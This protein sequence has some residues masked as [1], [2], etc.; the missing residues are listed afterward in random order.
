[1]TNEDIYSNL[2]VNGFQPSTIDL[3]AIVR[4][5]PRQSLLPDYDLSSDAFIIAPNSFNVTVKQSPVVQQRYAG[6]GAETNTFMIPNAE[7]TA[8][9]KLPLNVPNLGYTDPAFALLWD[10]CKLAYYGTAGVIKSRIIVGAGETVLSATNAVD[11]INFTGAAQIVDGGASEDVV[12]VSA[13]KTARTITILSP[14]AIT[15]TMDA[16]IIAYTSRSSDIEREPAFSLF[17]LREGVLSPVLV[18]KLTIDINAGEEIVVSVD[19]LSLNIDRTQQAEIKTVFAS[20]MSNF[21]KI[22]SPSQ[23]LNGSIVVL[24]ANNT[25]V[26]SDYAM[27][28]VLGDNLVAG[29]QTIDLPLNLITGA[30]IVIDNNL[31]NIHCLHSVKRSLVARRREN[32]FPFAAV[33]E[34]RNITGN[35][36]YRHSADPFVFAEKLS[37]PS[38]IGNGGFNLTFDTFKI[39]LPQVIWAPSENTGEV[40]GYQERT[41]NWIMGADYFNSMPILESL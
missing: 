31:K 24:S 13:N 14:V 21:A 27:E 34:G 36:K 22:S 11:F 33:S 41:L 35:I 38:G 9:F 30:Q 18:N 3:V 28:V 12:V 10:Y 26:N 32:S 39:K 2:G 37:G 19:L 23:I 4:N 7:I 17:S 15:H 20:L 25:I 16:E 5:S 6:E 40:E 29:N 1:M 8:T